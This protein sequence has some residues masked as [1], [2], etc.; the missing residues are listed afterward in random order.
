MFSYVKNDPLI[1]DESIEVN[2]NKQIVNKD[3]IKIKD[4]ANVQF[5]LYKETFDSTPNENDYTILCKK[6]W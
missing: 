4:G 5:N 6:R 3:G 1:T 2:V